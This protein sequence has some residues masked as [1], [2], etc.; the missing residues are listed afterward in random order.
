MKHEYLLSSLGILSNRTVTITPFYMACK[1][2]QFNVI[3]QKVTNKFKAFSINLN[4]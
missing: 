1:K 3:E 2:G 4:A